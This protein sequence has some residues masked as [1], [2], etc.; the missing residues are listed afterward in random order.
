M[1]HSTS[2]Q[3]FPPSIIMSKR[4][5]QTATN[6]TEEADRSAVR[7]HGDAGQMQRHWHVAG[8]PS[9]TRPAAPLSFWV[10]GRWSSSWRDSSR[11]TALLHKLLLF[12]SQPSEQLASTPHVQPLRAH[13][14]SVGFAW[15]Y[16]H[17]CT[18]TN[19]QT[20]TQIHI[21]TK[22]YVCMSWY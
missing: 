13:R 6:S 12:H 15:I 14:W 11:V 10:S 19:T 20:H 21:R 16:V 22:T 3:P 18:Y 7:P 8:T 9:L 4:R 5:D 17:A 2:R 1:T